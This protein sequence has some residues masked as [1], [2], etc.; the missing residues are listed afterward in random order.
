[1]RQDILHHVRTC[2][3]CQ[4]NK[5]RHGKPSGLLQPVE[6]PENSWECVSMDFVTG[7]PKSVPG[8][9]AILVMVDKHTKMAHFA[10]CK[11]TCNCY[12]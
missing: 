10:A 7:L 6:V 12:T 8:L 1:M 2:D 11:I 9:D 3:T 5:S 4:L